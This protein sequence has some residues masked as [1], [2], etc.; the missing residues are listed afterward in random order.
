MFIHFKITLKC[1]INWEQLE[2]HLKIHHFYNVDNKAPQNI[3]LFG[4]CH[5]LPLTYY[6]NKLF[7]HSYN[8]IVI[9]SWFYEK[10]VDICTD[11]YLKLR[12]EIESECL[13]VVNVEVDEY[14]K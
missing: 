9:V 3:V 12:Q 11:E 14:I 10:I 6:L 4:N 13:I 2:E 7:K 8:F 5:L 1:M